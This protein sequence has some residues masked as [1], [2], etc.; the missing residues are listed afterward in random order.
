M[1]LET[2]VGVRQLGGAQGHCTCEPMWKCSSCR[3]PSM[4]RASSSSTTATISR[5]RSPNLALSP[6]VVPQWPLRI[7]QRQRQS[8]TPSRNLICLSGYP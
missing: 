6:D 7:I 2:D 4:P 1:H 3:R 5:A 8:R